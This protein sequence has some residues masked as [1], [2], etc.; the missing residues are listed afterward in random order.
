[1]RTPVLIQKLLVEHAHRVCRHRGAVAQRPVCLHKRLLLVDEAPIV[2]RPER[3]IPLLHLHT[4]T[5]QLVRGIGFG[6][7]EAGRLVTDDRPQI[8]LAIGRSDVVAGH[9]MGGRSLG[10]AGLCFCAEEKLHGTTKRSDFRGSVQ[11]AGLTY[12]S[13]NGG[14]FARHYPERRSRS[15]FVLCKIP[16]TQLENHNTVLSRG[17]YHRRTTNGTSL[18]IVNG[19]AKVTKIEF[20]FYL[21]NL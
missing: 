9:R 12:R 8:R 17:I 10:V 3:L 2:S 1:M 7:F 4:A 16:Q 18:S 13:S 11:Y 19:F 6:A 20:W 15:V 14:R 21:H 5:A